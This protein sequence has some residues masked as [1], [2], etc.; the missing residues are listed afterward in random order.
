MM[1]VSLGG[2]LGG[3]GIDTTSLIEEMLAPEYE[4]LEE[5]NFDI[6]LVNAKADAWEDI[7]S[8]LSSFADI[9]NQFRQESAA[10][11][12]VFDTKIANSTD[13]STLSA[14][15][16]NRAQTGSYTIVT[17]QIAQPQVVFG[18][19]NP[20]TSTITSGFIT[21]NGASIQI[22]SSMDLSTIATNINNAGGYDL[23]HEVTAVVIDDRLV[24][25][26][27]SGEGKLIYGENGAFS[28]DPILETL[29]IIDTANSHASS[30]IYSDSQSS[31]TTP[32]SGSFSLNGAVITYSANQSL[33]DIAKSINNCS[34]FTIGDEVM[35]S[36]I[37][38]TNGDERLALQTIDSTI[39]ITIAD[40]GGNYN[41]VDGIDLVNNTG[42]G[43]RSGSIGQVSQSLIATING[44][45]IE[46]DVNASS[47]LIRNTA[48]SFHKVGTA[49]INIV[50][51][52]EE[53]EG[54]VIELVDIYNETRSL[55]S[56]YREVKL[57]EDDDFG[58]F[59]SDSE[60]I[61]L[62]NDLR[63]IFTGTV[64]MGDAA[65][66]DKAN[67]TLQNAAN[68]GETV[69]TIEGLNADK[70]IS[71]QTYLRLNNQIYQ[72]KAQ[73][74]YPVAGVVSL[75]LDK[76]LEEGL[77]AGTEVSLAERSASSVGIVVDDTGSNALN[78]ILKVDEVELRTQ[79]I[80]N[81]ERVKDIFNRSD[82]DNKP[83]DF[84][85]PVWNPSYEGIANRLHFFIDSYTKLSLFDTITRTID[86][87]KIG[88]YANEVRNI[89]GQIERQ[90]EK[91]ESKR[92]RLQTEMARM[93]SIIAQSQQQQSQLSSIMSSNQ[94]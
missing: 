85:S 54:R 77:D 37:V 29:G 92:T 50:N 87:I 9:I 71:D 59:A 66:W 63:S 88:S 23:G 43:T 36:V 16:S 68:A 20:D 21:L 11:T 80:L 81:I 76:P 69:I 67:V 33:S 26:T 19:K 22:N 35:A 27:A 91:I 24:L 13:E 75:V 61:K 90:E 73:S 1:S 53:I 3:S 8:Q 14:V 84:T 46:E 39:A 18:V 40:G 94:E 2:I 45:P 62:F 82:T 31:F 32:D 6:E 72:V 25:Q 15:V 65:P 56:N 70:K 38:D 10:S 48:L 58:V 41:L 57:N 60:M 44:V 42:Y 93:E 28:A 86:D 83:Y 51:D 55:I 7:G 4:K 74:D 5:L 79:L 78:G 17:E 89:E 47:D 34:D 52:Y 12:T 64:L 30:A 49:T